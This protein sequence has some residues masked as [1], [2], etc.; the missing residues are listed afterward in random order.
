METSNDAPTT[1]SART[2]AQ[3]DSSTVKKTLLGECYSEIY[4]FPCIGKLQ[5]GVHVLGRMMN[6]TKTV[7]GTATVSKDKASNIVAGELCDDWTAKNVYPMSRESA[8]ARIAKTYERFLYLMSKERKSKEKGLSKK[9]EEEAKAFNVSMNS[10][11]YDIR[12]TSKIYQKKLEGATN[13]KMTQEDEDF[14]QDN[15][16]GNY[17][18]YCKDTVSLNA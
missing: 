4:N 6:I 15:C 16:Y 7:Q 9:L 3:V 2:R 14:Y 18:A 13:V 5:K 1:P 10:V 12:A 8:A 11:A 17:I